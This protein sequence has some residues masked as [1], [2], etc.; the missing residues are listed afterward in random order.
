[1]ASVVAERFSRL[2]ADSPDQE[3]SDLAEQFVTAYGPVVDE[4][5]ASGGTIDLSGFAHMFAEHTADSLNQQQRRVL[6]EFERRLGGGT[7]PAGPAPE[8]PGPN[9]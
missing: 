5:A 1:M 3:I 9:E 2:G 7:R 8:V 4:F 6:A